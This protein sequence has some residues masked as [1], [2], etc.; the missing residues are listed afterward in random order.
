MSQTIRIEDTTVA[1]LTNRIKELEKVAEAAVATCKELGR[2]GADTEIDLYA[3]LR[4]A[5]Y[6][7][8]GPYGP[9]H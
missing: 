4:A 5:G 8:E 3:A 6:L 9:S 1:A 2:Y 7:K